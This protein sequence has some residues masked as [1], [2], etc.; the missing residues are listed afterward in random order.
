MLQIFTF[1]KTIKKEIRKQALLET[2][3]QSYLKSINNSAS[4]QLISSIQKVTP[5]LLAS[6]LV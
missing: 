2:E 5:P 6:G 1:I 3:K 4:K